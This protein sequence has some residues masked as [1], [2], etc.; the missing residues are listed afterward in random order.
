MREDGLERAA[1][2][3]QASFVVV[4]DSAFPSFPIVDFRGLNTGCRWR[5]GGGGGGGKGG[6][7][8][9]SRRSRV[10]DVA[11]VDYEHDGVADGIVA[12][13]HGAQGVLA[14]HVPDLEVRVFEGDGGDVLADGGHGGFGGLGGA[15]VEGF[16]GGEE[17]CFAGVVEA[18]EE[19][20]VFC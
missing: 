16:D 7:G 2:F 18:E 9:R 12:R 6:R 11:P 20:G 1:A 14:A 8:S 10:S 4:V 5:G 13:P 3:V 19:D 17:G 15:V